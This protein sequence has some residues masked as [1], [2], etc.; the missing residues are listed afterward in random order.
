MAFKNIPQIAFNVINV[1]GIV[2]LI[3]GIA[4]YGTDVTISSGYSL[5]KI[6]GGLGVGAFLLTV[7]TQINLLLQ[8]SEKSDKDAQRIKASLALDVKI[9][10]RIIQLRKENRPIHNSSSKLLARIIH[11]KCAIK[12]MPLISFTTMRMG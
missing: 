7:A 5:D 3:M 8:A 12:A 4:L 1:I 6:L 2:L 11:E 10:E 9:N